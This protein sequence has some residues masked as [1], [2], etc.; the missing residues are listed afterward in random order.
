MK[1]MFHNER[2]WRE[3]LCT[4]APLQSSSL[5]GCPLSLW[6]AISPFQI[7][8]PVRSARY[9]MPWASAGHT[10]GWVMP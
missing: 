1:S 2:S 6:R 4:L 5:L 9:F 3:G 10:P 7:A 8:V